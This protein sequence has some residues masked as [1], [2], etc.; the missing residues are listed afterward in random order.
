MTMTSMIMW[1][2]GF[3]TNIGYLVLL[4]VIKLHGCLFVF[5]AGCFITAIYA[6]IFIPET[7]GKSPESVA[8]LL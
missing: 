6:I 3:S 4:K 7:K 1:I 5:S 2:L 8:K